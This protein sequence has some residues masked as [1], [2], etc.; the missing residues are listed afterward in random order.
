MTTAAIHFLLCLDD[1]SYYHL[2]SAEKVLIVIEVSPYP[3]TSERDRPSILTRSPM[4]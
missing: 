1:Y 3:V 4:P 2:L